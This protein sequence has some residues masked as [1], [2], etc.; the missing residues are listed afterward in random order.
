[1][2]LS[3]L[4][5]LT[6]SPLFC[7]STLAS[8]VELLFFYSNGCRHSARL[9]QFL[10]TRIQPTYSVTIKKY[11][12]HDPANADL[13]MQLAHAYQSQEITDKGV[14]AVFI[15]DTALQGSDRLTFRKLEE[16]VRAAVRADAPSPLTHLP[17]ETSKLKENLTLPVLITAAALDAVNPC[18]FGVLALLLSSIF[19]IAKTH[20]RKNV[21]Y[22]GLAFTLAVFICYILMGFGLFSAVQITGLQHDV[23]I[24]VAVLAVIIGLWNIKDYFWYN[25][26]ANIEVPQ[27]WRPR[28]KRIVS[29]V[30]SWPGCFVAG[31][32]CS[33]FLL[34]C[35]SGPY[36]VI[37]G[38][39][40][41][42]A[43]R[44]QAVWLLLL[45]NF[46]F[47]IPFLIITFGI[48][49]GLTSPARVE[50]WRQKR[51]EKLHLG[52]GLFMLALGITLLV[53][54]SLRII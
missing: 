9:N 20:K 11:E 17:H 39:L 1:M 47:I 19:R 32:L 49:I 51:I 21:I 43:T 31:V 15:H 25:R 26:G 5:I 24:V 54:L 29:G 3:V 34:P 12:I 53:L 30:I 40:S 46:I 22:A 52:T 16:A 50:M 28:L 14:P 18:T 33:F 6:F 8:D 37:I 35:T 7:R 4:F 23:Y 10:T 45:Y 2:S 42:T 38:M 27:S 36:V 48:G 44:P 41:D 13:M